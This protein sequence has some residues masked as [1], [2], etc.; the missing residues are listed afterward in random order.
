MK[1]EELN[2]IISDIEDMLLKSV[3]I[4]NNIYLDGIWYSII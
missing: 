1:I 3:H 2:I 4:D